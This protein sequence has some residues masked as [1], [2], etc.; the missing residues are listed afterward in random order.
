[1]PETFFQGND[2]EA[3]IIHIRQEINGHLFITLI[4]KE[5]EGYY[6]PMHEEFFVDQ[7][8][9]SG[10]LGLVLAAYLNSLSIRAYVNPDTMDIPRNLRAVYSVEIYREDAYIK[11]AD[12]PTS[13]TASTASRHPRESKIP[14]DK[15]PPGKNER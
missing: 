4:P 12:I 14:G 7:S 6:T 5:T 15:K 8:E 1:M 9:H 13:S 11:I 10:I 2:F 3:K